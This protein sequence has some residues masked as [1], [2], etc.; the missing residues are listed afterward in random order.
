M[1]RSPSF[2]LRLVLFIGGAL[3]LTSLTAP[4]VSWGLAAVSTHRF[5]FPRV[6]DRVLQ[7]V[8]AVGV[9]PCR[10]WLGVGSWSTLGLGQRERRGDAWVGLALA[11]GGM[12]ILLGWMYWAD[13]LR[14]AWRYPLG[15]GVQKALLGTVGAVLIGCGEELLFRGIL[16]GG[17]MGQMRRGPAVAWTTAVYAVVHFLRGGKQVGEVTLASGFERLAS[18]FAPLA[19]T[20]IAPGLVGFVLLGLV[21]AYARLAS[22]S[23]YLP[24]GLHVG[25]VFTLRVGRLAVDYPVEPGLLWGLRRPALVSGLAGWLALGA[26]GCVLAWVLARRRRQHPDAA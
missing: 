3:L 13:A 12:A 22:G 20:E 9:V 14:L 4:F 5:S 19:S 15:K 17:L 24:I 26:T 8:A 6:Y 1:M 18:A 25:W 16:L 2:A 10:R 7:I 23:L 11:L 21:L